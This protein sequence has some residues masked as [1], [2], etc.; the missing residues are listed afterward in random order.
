MRL[1]GSGAKLEKGQGIE[2]GTERMGHGDAMILLS[3]SG[4]GTSNFKPH[5][6]PDP[7]CSHPFHLLTPSPDP[8]TSNS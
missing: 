1:P 2:G 6:F 8:D 3:P 5:P 7:T 4:A